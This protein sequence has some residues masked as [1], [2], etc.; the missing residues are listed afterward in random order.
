MVKEKRTLNP[1]DAQRRVER[2]RENK[3]NKE[4][5]DK[6]REVASSLKKNKNHNNTQTNEEEIVKP[7]EAPENAQWIPILPE[8]ARKYTFPREPKPPPP[9]K[10]VAGGKIPESVTNMKYPPPPPPP[11]KLTTQQERSQTSSAMG[12]NREVQVSQVEAAEWDQLHPYIPA[13]P[14]AEVAL[15]ATQSVSS[16]QPSH[17]IAPNTILKPTL[18][19]EPEIRN[20]QQ[21]LTV[22]VPSAIARANKKRKTEGDG[23]KSNDATQDVEETYADFLA[24]IAESTES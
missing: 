19:A 6:A 8:E 17:S 3:K 4:A 2:L 16:H 15:T 21:E 23:S 22:F 5:R 13:V 10:N 9:R 12:S 20:L 7:N 24:E 11:T 14:S 1:A 18:E